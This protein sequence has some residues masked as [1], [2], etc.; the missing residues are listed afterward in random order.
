[1]DQNGKNS[2][3]SGKNSATRKLAHFV[4]NTRA[5][6]LSATPSWPS[7]ESSAIL[8]PARRKTLRRKPFRPPSRKPAIKLAKRWPS[9]LSKSVDIKEG[10]WHISICPTFNRK[11]QRKIVISYFQLNPSK[12]K[13]H[14]RTTQKST[15]KLF[16]I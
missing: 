2:A 5:W 11:L 14:P 9:R 3:T 16:L 10:F 4:T 1:M 15:Q 7:A 8:L 12:S 13:N 6:A